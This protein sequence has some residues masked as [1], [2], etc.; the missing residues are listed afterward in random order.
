MDYKQV[1]QDCLRLVGGKENVNTAAHCAT[2]LRLQLADK[3]KV[4]IKALKKLKD[5]IDVKE[6]GAQTQ[7]IIGPSVSEV[8]KEFTKLIGGEKKAPVKAAGG[9]PQRGAII[10]QMMDIV[11]GIFGPI[12]PVI[13]GA[14]MIKAVLAILTLVGMS[15]DSNE[16]YMLS[17]I[18]DAAF[19]FLPVILGFSCGNKF[20]CNPFLGA[21]IGAAMV[22]PNWTALVSA[23]EAFS[24]IGIPVTLN[25][26]SSTVL[27]VILTVWFMSYVERLADKY[28]PNVIKAITKPLVTLAVTALVGFIAIMPLGSFVGRI[29]AIGINY[30]NEHFGVLLYTLIGGCWPLFVFAGMHMAIFP[31]IQVAQYTEWGYETTGPAI[32]AANLSVGSACLAAALRSKNSETRNLGLSSGIT[33]LCGIT[34]PA[35]YGFIFKFKRPL[36]AV[37]AG[38]ASGGLFAGIMQLKRYTMATPSIPA[39]GIFIGEGDPMNFVWALVTAGIAIIVSFTVAWI[40]GVQEEPE[41][42]DESSEESAPA[43]PTVSA[44]PDTA[45]APVAGE[46]IVLEQ[47]EDEVFSQGVLGKGCGIHPTGTVICAPC[48]GVITTV[49]DTRHAVGILS[50]K[51]MEMLIHV[52]IDT[53]DMEGKGFTMYCKEGDK[54][55]KGQKLLSFDPKAIQAA[56]HKDTVAVLVTTTDDYKDVTLL[57]TGQTAVGDNL[58]SVK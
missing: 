38:G 36:I 56:G 53:V 37:M 40:L 44:G 3:S 41:E 11:S 48:S 54:V 18:A 5:V 13:A 29:L 20:G 50:D 43:I 22:H 6:M 26:Y 25:T 8:Y 19:Y 1:A 21:V 4:D 12:V 52:G 42:E 57:K 17:F 27:P 33:A 10:S 23:G 7:I 2:R 9:K 32:L 51:G 14:G 55:K 30:L 34:E 47:I 35:L 28:S 45:C 46:A 58:I 24:F 16:Y 15:S 49:A 31:P 39:L